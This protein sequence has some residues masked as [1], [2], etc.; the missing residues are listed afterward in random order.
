MEFSQYVLLVM[1]I[2]HTSLLQS[3]IERLFGQSY[4]LWRIVLLYNKDLDIENIKTKYKNNKNIIWKKNNDHHIANVF[5]ETLKYFL[6]NDDYSHLCFINDHDKYYPNFIKFLLDGKRDFVYGN[7]HKRKDS[8]IEAREYKDKEDLIQNY[9]G[10]CNT[11]WSKN[12]IKKIGI[13]DILKEEV[14][15]YDYYIRTFDVL[16]K[17][18]IKYIKIALNTC[19]C[20][21]YNKVRSTVFV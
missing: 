3:T 10:L 16:T 11:M 15:L 17:N 6:E 18:E 4:S 14:A 21:K 2:E 19:L 1:N 20:E 13:F 9:Q 7:Y 5:N 8:I 12:A